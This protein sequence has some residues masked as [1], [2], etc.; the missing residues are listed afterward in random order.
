MIRSMVEK[1]SKFRWTMLICMSF[2]VVTIF[3]YAFMQPSS[4]E[5]TPYGSNVPVAVKT[6]ETPHAR[7]LYISS[8]VI[9]ELN[10]KTYQVVLRGMSPTVVLY[11]ASWCGHCRSVEAKL[12]IIYFSSSLIP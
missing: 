2:M 8:S 1:Y 7:G 10:E 9:D 12:S 6:E 3:L 11:Y 5:G 4:K